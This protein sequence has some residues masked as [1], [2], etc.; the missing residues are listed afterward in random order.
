[1]VLE[2][3]TAALFWVS[4]EGE[5]RTP[6]LGTGILDSITRAKIVRELDVVEGEYELDDLLSAGEAFLASTT[7]EVQ[8]V[9]GVDDHSLEAPGP[10][11]DEAGQAF[12]RVLAQTLA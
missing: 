8:P 9:A 12:A 6:A 4:T 7:R 2:A 3:P 10:R 1:V 11:T 5:L